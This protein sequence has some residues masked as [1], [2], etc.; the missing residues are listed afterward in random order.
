MAFTIQKAKREKSKARICFMGTSG[1]GKTLSALFLA[2][3]M[4]G[5][6]DKV[7]VIDTERKRSLF[8]ANRTDLDVY[9][10]EEGFVIGEFYH[11]DFEPDFTV[12]RYI[13]AMK[14]A[15]KQVGSDG[16]VIIDSGSHAWKG[17]GGV[18]EYKED[19]AAQRGK[20]DFSAWNDAGKV[21]NRFID[22]IMDLDCH[23]IV[24]LRSKAD[25]VQEKD[26]ETN[27]TTVKKLGMK[28]E[29][30]DDFEYEFMLVL[31]FDKETHFATII[32]DNTFLE[33][34]NFHGTITPA[35]G[36]E[37]KEWI[38][39]GKEP[40]ILRCENCGNIIKGAEGRNGYLSPEEVA[41]NAQDTFGKRLCMDCCIELANATNDENDDDKEDSE[42]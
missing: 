25:Y 16:V 1:S 15:Q 35:L 34:Q 29:Q 37:I 5:D 28:P 27:K 17:T 22:A 41:E 23:V 18:L 26:P 24:T 2:Y 20:T 42:E 12:D 3:G 40:V 10:H 9:A 32:K 36:K 38:S 6:W 19:I 14:L 33:A 11:I 30:R 8:Y 7:A 13:E 31:D 4:T 39:E 21:Q